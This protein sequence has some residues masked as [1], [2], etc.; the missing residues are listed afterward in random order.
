MSHA[1]TTA[2]ATAPAA[3]RQSSILTAPPERLL[4]ML[5]DGASRFLTQ[6]AAAMREREIARA[7]DRLQRGEAIIEE[8]L[9]TLDLS[10]GE[11]AERLQA[12]YVFCRRRLVEAR[13]E[14]DPER[15][16][17]VRSLLGELR[18]AWAEI[19]PG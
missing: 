17:E 11:V 3:Y 10:A 4:V 1:P 19:A 14:Q 12:L 5:Y 8:L 18:R 9:S 16:D 7:N 6:A 2:Y 15:I 13:I